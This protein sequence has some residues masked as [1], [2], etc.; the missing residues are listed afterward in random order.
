MYVCTTCTP[1][2]TTILQKSKMCSDECSNKLSSKS[3]STKLGDVQS[4]LCNTLTQPDV[5]R[6]FDI[7][8]AS[9]MYHK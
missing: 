6:C 2:Q 8:R 7:E 9:C 4:T 5:A 1:F 3:Q